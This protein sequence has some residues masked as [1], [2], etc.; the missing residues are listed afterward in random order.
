VAVNPGAIRI[1]AT[2]P[3]HQPFDVDV[4]ATAGEEI[5]AKTDLVPIPV[6]VP[7]LGPRPLLPPAA[8]LSPPE[9]HRWR[10]RTGTALVGAGA[11][12][13]A[14]G[15]VWLAINGKGTCDPTPG[16]TCQRNYDTSLQGWLAVGAGAALAGAGVGLIVWHGHDDQLSLS[17]GPNS[18]AAT[19][20]F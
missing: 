14:V 7:S 8:P 11:A 19:G 15:V 6:A 10:Q 18:F 2:A 3:G 4:V 9:D 17:V 12:A 20:R 16:G 1:R 5:V 13:V